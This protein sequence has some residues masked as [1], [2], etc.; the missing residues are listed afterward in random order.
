MGR[1]A[2]GVNAIRLG[3]GDRVAGMDVIDDP[4]LDLMVI[5]ANGYGKRT[6]LEAYRQIGRYGVGVHTLAKS[7]QAGPIIEARV[8]RPG[9]QIALITAG[10]RA[11]RT[12]VDAIPHRGR[13]T[14][15]V[16]LMNLSPGEMLVSVALLNSAR[17]AEEGDEIGLE[18]EEAEANQLALI[19][20]GEEL[21]EEDF[22]DYESSDDM[23]EE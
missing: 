16:H 12:T 20:D 3:K 7:D 13:A 5:T 1:A 22:D 4:S 18:I 11:L 9:D 2:A 6:P 10:G 23:E 21:T 14:L 15:G 19:D 17:Q 8:V